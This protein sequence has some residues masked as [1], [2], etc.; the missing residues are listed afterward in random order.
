MIF[1][2]LDKLDDYLASSVR[3][4]IFPG[5]RILVAKEKK[6]LYDKSFG[7]LKNDK[8]NTVDINTVYDIPSITKVAA[9]TIAV[10]KLYEEGKLDLNAKLGRYLAF[11]KGTDK[12]YLVIKDILMH[13][14]GLKSWI[15]FY[16][17]LKK[18]LIVLKTRPCHL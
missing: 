8:R 12:E 15:P 9:T 16:Q 4:G 18:P 5:C 11:T 1:Q 10:M 3:N 7:Y 13:Q 2:E 6:V 17:G 14:A